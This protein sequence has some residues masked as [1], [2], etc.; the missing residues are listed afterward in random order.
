MDQA[1]S[2]SAMVALIRASAC[3]PVDSRRQAAGMLLDVLRSAPQHD[4]QAGMAKIQA[5]AGQDVTAEALDLVEELSLGG[6]ADL[7]P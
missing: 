4:L 6:P 7:L 2:T 3:E 5:E 1:Q